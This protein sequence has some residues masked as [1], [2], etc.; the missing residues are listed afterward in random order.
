MKMLEAERAIRLLLCPSKL[1]GSPPP[2]DL[3]YVM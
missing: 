2:D 3:K 1:R